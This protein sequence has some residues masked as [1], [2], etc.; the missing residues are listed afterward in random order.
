[1]I[2]HVIAAGFAM[3]LLA[4]HF[5]RGGNVALASG[6]ALLPFLLLGKRRFALRIVQSAL[7]AGVAIWIH[8]AI[9]LTRMRV[10]LGA[11]WLRMLLI[12]AAVSLFT[13]LCV[14][15]L[16]AQAVKRRFPTHAGKRS[17]NGIQRRNR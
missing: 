4:A 15:L 8:T 5:F 7:A 10:Q 11:P 1:M 12:L 2:P 3:L 16:N 13:G 6:C 17:K 14:W 9:V